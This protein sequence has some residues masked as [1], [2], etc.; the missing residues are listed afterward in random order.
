MKAIF[1]IRKTDNP[2]PVSGA[3]VDTT[4]LYAAYSNDPEERYATECLNFISLMGS[5]GIPL[6]YTGLVTTELD[7]VIVREQFK[8]IQRRQALT[9]WEEVFEVDHSAM[10][11]AQA[12]IDRI[13]SAIGAN[14][15]L[16][17]LPLEL[18]EEFTSARRRIMRQYRLDIM[19]ASHIAAMEQ[20][21]LNTIVTN[22]YGYTRVENINIYTA[23]RRIIRLIG[24]PGVSTNLLPSKGVP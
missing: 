12:E 22:D 14:K 1:D 2:L 16:V 19:D 18:D 8:S 20:W 15:T 17:Y 7:H 3:Y 21:E 6:F 23:S 4:V 24:S 9:K 5:L 13:A 11:K 10:D